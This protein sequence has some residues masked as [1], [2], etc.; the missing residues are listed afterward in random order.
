MS[1]LKVVISSEHLF[2]RFSANGL[3]SRFIRAI[4]SL[5]RITSDS[6]MAA[7][8]VSSFFVAGRRISK[9]TAAGRF[10]EL[11]GILADRLRGVSNPVIH[12][13]AVSTGITSLDLLDRLH[14]EGILPRFYISDKFVRCL[15]VRCGPVTRLYDTYG[16]LLYAHVGLV[17]ADP[18][19]SWFFPVSRLLFRL[20][21]A[22]TP[23]TTGATEILL[24]DRSVQDNLESG[25]LTHLDYDIFLSHTDIQFDVIRCMNTVTRRYFTPERITQALLNLRRS[26]KP[27][28]LFL[29]GRT[30]PSGRNDA[31]FFRLT[32]G[33]FVPERVV[34]DG[35]DIHEIVVGLPAQCANPLSSAEWTNS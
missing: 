5:L 13:V 6:D 25:S 30:L 15:Y 21:A 7:R 22:K 17:V 26:L 18:L 34:N 3:L 27:G 2:K 32:D 14:G 20:L 12:D 16:G 23:C 8:I 9:E 1:V 4:P 29:V 19:A 11:D 35:S 28:G 10:R 33:C 31:T 24:Y